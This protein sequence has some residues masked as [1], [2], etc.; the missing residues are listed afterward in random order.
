M[1]RGSIRPRISTGQDGGC[2]DCAALPIRR[3]F[4]FR[5]AGCVVERLLRR[6][7]RLRAFCPL[8]RSIFRPQMRR[9]VCV[10]HPFRRIVHAAL[11][12]RA[13]NWASSSPRC[14]MRSGSPE[15]K[16]RPDHRRRSPG[17]GCPVIASITGADAALVV[18]EPTVSGLHDLERVASSRSIWRQIFVVN[19]ADINLA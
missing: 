6:L 18:T 9:T 1:S 8:T 3:H 14:A 12:I 5:A 4:A 17:T 7:R 16:R 2:A 13:E 19:K 11:D 15:R 10:E